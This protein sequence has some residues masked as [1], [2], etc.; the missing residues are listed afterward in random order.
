MSYGHRLSCKW[1]GTCPKCPLSEEVMD[2]LSLGVRKQDA[3]GLSLASVNAHIVKEFW[4]DVCCRMLK[5]R[6]SPHA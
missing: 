6:E 3:G 1:I 4:P 2:A 5:S